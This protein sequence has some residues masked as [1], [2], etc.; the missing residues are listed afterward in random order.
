LRGLLV[1]SAKAPGFFRQLQKDGHLERIN[2]GDGTEVFG[3]K[4]SLDL[5]SYY[6]YIGRHHRRFSADNLVRN[7][8]EAMAVALGHNSGD[9]RL[10]VCFCALQP[11]NSDLTRVSA[12]LARN[13]DVKGVFLIRDPR[14]HLA[15]KLMRN[16]DLNLV[17]FCRRQNRY[18]GEIEEFSVKYG[19]TLRV[20]FEELVTDTEACM[21]RVC[22]F[23][24]VDYYPELLDYTQGGELSQSNSSFAA[25]VGIDREV[26][27]RYQD[28]LSPESIIY[29]EKNCRPE[30]FWHE[31]A[32]S[33]P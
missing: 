33:K 17:R 26:V 18:W 19:P 24:G 21:R 9:Q 4:N 27:T 25:T 10:R 8:V 2:A 28:T 29:L 6:E 20:R 16:P 11:S 5:N 7:H 15:S 1:T 12:V 32:D 3:S 23:V 22:E 30:L 14:S 13:Y 31:P